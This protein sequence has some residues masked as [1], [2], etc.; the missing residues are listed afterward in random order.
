MRAHEDIRKC[1][2]GNAAVDKSPKKEK[3]PIEEMKRLKRVGQ[4][5][6]KRLFK[7]YSC[8]AP[9]K[10][11]L[12]LTTP[13]WHFLIAGINSVQPDRVGV[14]LLHDMI[15]SKLVV[16]GAFAGSREFRYVRQISCLQP[17]LLLYIRENNLRE[18][19]CCAY[20]RS[21]YIPCV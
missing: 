6:T 9:T 15:R 8:S 5:N 18:I 14:F 4:R 16:V 7:K 13:N 11:V 12:S 17:V 3:C 1:P 2:L 10:K 19:D 21:T 20:D